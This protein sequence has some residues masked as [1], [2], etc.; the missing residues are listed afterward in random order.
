[1]STPTVASEA[2]ATVPA[3]ECTCV[4]NC[5]EDPATACG[6]SGQQHVHPDNGLGIYGPCPVHPG[7]PGD[8]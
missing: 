4:E 5:G 8:L 3:H 6:L 1:M 7:V 2:P